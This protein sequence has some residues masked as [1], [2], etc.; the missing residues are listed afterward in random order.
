MN[1]EELAG[2]TAHPIQVL[3]MS[4]YFDPPTKVRA[5]ELGLNV[6]EFY[7]LGR[8]GV[9]GNVDSS[10]VHR[11]FTFFHPDTIAALWDSPL[12]KADPVS[13]AAH[14]VEAAYA[15]ADRTFGDLD[16][17][18]LANFAAA[19]FK[20]IANVPLGRHLLVDG[21]RQFTE[22]DNPV[23]AAYLATILLRELRGGAHI[24]AVHRVGLA[25]NE[26]AYLESDALFTLH[27]Y[28]EADVPVVTPQLEAQKLE[29]EALTASI[30][31]EYFAVLDEAERQQLAGATL[32]MFE[33][34]GRPVLVSELP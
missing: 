13:T 17:A 9:L 19:A 24:D 22:P 33:A 30:M 31:A 20:V 34:L 7:G 18:D 28:A 14:Y 26:A 29:A 10:V 16:E 12:A 1:A 2:V 4:F 6:F 3:G 27:G 23:H 25:P 8:A 15:F 5:R 21:Y 32:A 11:A